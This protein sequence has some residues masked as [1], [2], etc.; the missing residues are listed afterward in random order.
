MIDLPFQFSHD[1]AVMDSGMRKMGRTYR[2][3]NVFQ[4]SHDFAVMDR[5][6]GLLRRIT[7]WLFQSSHDFAVMDRRKDH[8]IRHDLADLVSI[9]PRLCSHGQWNDY[10]NTTTPGNGVSIEPRLC[11]HGQ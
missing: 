9:E 11:S 10:M 8:E 3:P 2:D 1:F 4:F 5:K 6:R 7:A